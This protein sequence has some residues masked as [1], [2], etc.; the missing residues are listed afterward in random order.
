MSS[1]RSRIA[2]VQAGFS[3]DLRNVKH[4]AKETHCLQSC[5]FCQ[6]CFSNTNEQFPIFVGL[7]LI[8]LETQDVVGSYCCPTLRYFEHSPSSPPRVISKYALGLYR[9]RRPPAWKTGP[10]CH[11]VCPDVE[12]LASPG[13]SRSESPA[14]WHSSRQDGPVKR[15]MRT[16]MEMKVK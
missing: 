7:W 6:R 2:R 16:R 4:D 1:K 8:R 5:P 11:W 12:H 15:R 3:H 10:S 13:Q 14:P 9:R